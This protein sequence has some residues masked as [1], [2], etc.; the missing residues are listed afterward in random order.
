MGQRLTVCQD[1]G[2][3]STERDF[4]RW[5]GAFIYQFALFH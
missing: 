3:F 4:V 5:V 1:E 2:D